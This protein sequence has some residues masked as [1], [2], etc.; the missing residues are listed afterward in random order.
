MNRLYENLSIHQ[1][2]NNYPLKL[3]H[4]FF[5]VK[6]SFIKFYSSLFFIYITLNDIL[7]MNI[8]ISIIIKKVLN[9]LRFQKF[10]E[11]LICHFLFNSSFQLSETFH[12]VQSSTLCYHRWIFFYY[13]WI[14]KFYFFLCN[15][16]LNIIIYNQL[17]FLEIKAKLDFKI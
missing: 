14:V 11:N 12:C 16:T 6:V 1:N 4:N 8:C 5:F 9:W 13:W 15:L 17:F 10:F 3:K 2:F 7:I